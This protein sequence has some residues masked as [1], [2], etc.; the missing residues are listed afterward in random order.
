VGSGAHFFYLARTRP[1]AVGAVAPSRLPMDRVLDLERLIAPTIEG[2]DYDLVRV[3][4]A[5]FGRGRTLQVMAERKDRREMTVEDCALISRT[6]SA[7]LDVED[8]IP[9]QYTLE[10]SSPGIDRPLV[11]RADYARFAGHLARIEADAPVDGRRRWRGRIEALSD[12]GETVLIAC[13]GERCAVPFAAITRAKL[14]L[15]DA[16]I[17]ASLAKSDAKTG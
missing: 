11:R 7:M 14:V 12:D 13:D 16:L 8:P 2:L 1:R 5:G 9:G 4:L 6:L 10:V 3:Q 17:A 15:T